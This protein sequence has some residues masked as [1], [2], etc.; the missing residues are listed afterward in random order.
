[1]S[2]TCADLQHPVTEPGPDGI[3]HPA[4]EPV[5][6][7]NIGQDLVAD[8]AAV[9]VVHDG[10]LR[11]GQQIDQDVPGPPL[12]SLDPGPTLEGHRDFEDPEAPLACLDDQFRNDVEPVRT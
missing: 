1:V 12:G 10:Q 6:A 4:V 3:R 2:D 9:Q 11:D 8:V 5:S 7:R